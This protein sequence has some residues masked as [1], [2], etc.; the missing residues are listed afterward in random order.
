MHLQAQTI[1]RYARYERW[2]W[3][4]FGITWLAYAGFYLTRKSFSVAKI[5]IEHDP[6]LGLSDAQ[7]AWIDGAYLVAYAVGQFVFGMAG[8]RWGTRKVVAAGLLGS[9][10][11]AVAMGASTWTVMLGV[12]F[13]IQ[14]LC[15]SSGWAPLSKN[16]SA[17]FSRR[18]RGM[19]MG[20]WCTNYALGGLLASMVAGIAGD[21]LGWR[22]AFYVP[23]GAL[24]VVAILFL[25][26]QR[27]RPEDVGLPPIERYHGETP[28]TLGMTGTASCEPEGSW[29]VIREVVTNRMVLLFAAVY[30]L[31]K[32]ARYAILFWGPK[33]IHARLN[34]NMTE[35][36]LLSGLFELA[37]PAAALTG[38]YLSDRVFGTRR[39]P[40]CVICLLLLGGL[41]ISFNHFPVSRWML[42]VSF[43]AIGMLLF[44]PDSLVVGAAA[45]DFGTKRGAST[46]AGVINGMGSIGAILGGTLPGFFNQRWGWDGVF[47]LLGGMTLLAALILLPRW[48]AL[49][50]GAPPRRGPEASATA[51]SDE[52]AGAAV[53]A[54]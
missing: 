27:N 54:R 17:F 4:I 11:A 34:S 51:E 10:I 26:F 45:V 25:V 1:H 38:G 49:P 42:G 41:L 46:A 50:T 24:T 48:N 12:F 37:G 36:G 47:T 22:Y 39:V 14:G 35:S 20:L 23:A 5:E 29:S 28:A 40:V 2:R 31:L 16:M 33:F 18:E 8:D 21:Q 15:Q 13:L 53:G 6:A 19:V 3:Q 43:F 44:A 9:V 30:F 7:M 32:P 52:P